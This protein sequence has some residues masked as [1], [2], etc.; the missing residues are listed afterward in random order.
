MRRI[1][2]SIR[3]GG[4]GKTTTAVNL[5]HALALIGRRVL[6]IDADSQGQTAALLG[7][8]P[9]IGLA[10]VLAGRASAREAMHAARDGLDLIAG[11][12]E[13]VEITLDRSDAIRTA[14]RTAGRG[15]DFVLVDTAPGF[16]MLAAG[17]LRYASEVLTPVSLEPLTLHGL[18]DFVRIIE[19]TR[20]DN[21]EL[22]LRYVLPTFADGRVA[23]TR[24]ILADL[25]EHFP[26][27]ICRPIRYNVRLSESAAF[28]QTI[29]EYAP[30]SYGAEDYAALAERIAG[31]T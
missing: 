14:L 20:E 17:V 25:E 7:V 5:A 24:E 18:V 15:Y 23:K 16:D 4:T 6:L 27:Q 22:S 1:A 10:D 26:D 28:G 9:E 11:G 3:K 12:P 19:G 29:H 2:V 21:R 13:L 30:T 8:A 31:D